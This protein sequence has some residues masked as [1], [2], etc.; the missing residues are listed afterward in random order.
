MS[1][2]QKACKKNQDFKSLL[3]W[4]A[5][6]HVSTSMVYEVFIFSTHTHIHKQTDRWMD[7]RYIAH[8]LPALLSYAVD[9]CNL[10][11]IIMH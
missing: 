8:Y 3:V 1:A 5:P 4:E 9:T 11:L 2:K 10:D 7:G 6:N